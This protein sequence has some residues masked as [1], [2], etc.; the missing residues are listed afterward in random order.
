MTILAVS[1]VAG[2]V[3]A[4]FNCTTADPRPALRTVVWYTLLPV[5]KLRLLANDKVERSDQRR[6]ARDVRL[7]GGKLIVDDRGAGKRVVLNAS[8]E[9]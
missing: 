3:L 5:G 8:Q 6:G 4:A 9:L 2:G 7:K 1:R